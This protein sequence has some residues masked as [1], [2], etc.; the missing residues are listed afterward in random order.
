[1]TLD[2]VG[3]ACIV[4]ALLAHALRTHGA[5]FAAIWLGLTTVAN[6]VVDRFGGVGLP[7][8]IEPSVAAAAGVYLAALFGKGFV[9]RTRFAGGVVPFAA[10]ASACAVAVALTLSTW[11]GFDAQAAVL[12]LA[13]RV[14]LF[15]AA[16]RTISLRTQH[17]PT[18][19][20]ILCGVG[21]VLWA[22]EIVVTR[23]AT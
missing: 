1:M 5:W 16:Y 13:L 10:L 22:V 6:V 7:G 4:A 8:G 19:L 12:A 3:L 17:D 21:P 14:F 11:R 23:A 20:A 18:K 9:E 15:C 2:E